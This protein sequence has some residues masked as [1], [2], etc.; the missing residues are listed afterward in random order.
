MAAEVFEF[1]AGGNRYFDSMY[2]ANNKYFFIDTQKHKFGFIGSSRLL[3]L[4]HNY[5][6][7]KYKLIHFH[8]T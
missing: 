2:V 3:Y 6:Y 5:Y 8:L 1:Q 4:D 7:L